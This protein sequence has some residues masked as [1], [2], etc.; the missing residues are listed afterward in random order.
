MEL[1]DAII[2][3]YFKQEEK[4]QPYL[5]WKSEFVEGQCYEAIK[6]IK[7]VLEQEKNSDADCFMQI[8]EIIS[9]LEQIGITVSRHDF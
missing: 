8:E 6:R 9:A 1:Y 3:H 4:C 2:S 7:E 5:Q